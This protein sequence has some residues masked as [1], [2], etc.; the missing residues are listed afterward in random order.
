MKYIYRGLVIVNYDEDTKQLEFPTD[1]GIV[2][3]THVRLLTEDTK[4][5]EVFFHNAY[6]HQMGGAYAAAADL[7][8]TVVN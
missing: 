4:L 2:N 6:L 5:L 1:D 8:D 3:I 7:T